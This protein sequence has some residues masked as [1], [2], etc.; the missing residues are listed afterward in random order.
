[1]VPWMLAAEAAIYTLG[2]A[3]YPFGLAIARDVSP[4]MVCPDF[5]TN[6]GARKCF[7]TI[8]HATFI[9]F[10]PGEA[11]KMLMVWA[12][13]PLAWYLL[14]LAHKYG[15]SGWRPVG[16]VS[17][18]EN[19]WVDVEQADNSP[20]EGDAQVHST[21]GVQIELAAGKQRS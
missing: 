13:V 16:G 4:A 10:I 14:I 5:L 18:S 20:R 11:V 9:P 15:K 17:V 21:A 3:W 1:M 19:S 6:E 2:M 12:T 8:A 7:S